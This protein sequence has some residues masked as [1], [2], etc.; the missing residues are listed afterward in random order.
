[1]ISRLPLALLLALPLALW[2]CTK[3]PGE[4]I[5]IENVTIIDPVS[6]RADAQRVVVTNGR[7]VGVAP[8]SE[9]APSTR[10]TLDAAGHFL[11]PGLWDMHVHFL[12]EP[13]LTDLMSDLFLDYGITSVR[14]TGGDLA[15]LRA[16]RERMTN[17]D[18]PEPRLYFSGPL[19]DGRF[20]VYDGGDPGRP[21]LGTGIPD[22]AL[23]RQYVRELLAAGADFIKIY[24]LVD[25]E[26]YRVLA[27][28]ARALGLPIASHVPLLMTADQAGPMADSME[29]LR[30]LELACAANWQELLATRQQIVR[31]F[32]EGRG[33]DLRSSLHSLQRVPAIQAY[34][35][36]RCDEVLAM[37]TS[38]I[39]VPT[40]RLNTVAIVQPFQHPDWPRALAALPEPVRR[41]WQ[42]QADAYRD[43]A[44]TADRTFSDW[45]RFLVGRLKAHGVPIGAGTDT[46]IGIGIPGW[47]LHTELEQLVDAG[48]TPLEAI[49]AATVQA[50]GFLHLEHEMGRILPGMRADLVLLED[51]PLADIRNTRRIERVM[52]DGRWVRERRFQG[53][54]RSI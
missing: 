33:Y 29:H 46:P 38:T 16:L 43:A 2:G 45:S 18:A 1:M 19:L 41:A 14:D 3:P 36:A 4:D 26:V 5:A 7:I 13:A 50:A 10:E 49:Y 28:E 20:V 54:V 30:N 12:Y 11:I 27:D 17:D 37:L 23:A 52:L 15:Q 31:E 21:K 44:P 42:A 40:L 35:E 47:S 22:E 8:M 25:P 6:G 34:D 39:Q 53:N 32:V 51:D 48:L 24:E 9:P